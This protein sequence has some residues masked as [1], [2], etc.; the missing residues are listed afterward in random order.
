MKVTAVTRLGVAPRL[1]LMVGRL[2]VVSLER[3]VE[4]S[5]AESRNEATLPF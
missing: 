1:P 2:G 5:M 3:V 4:E